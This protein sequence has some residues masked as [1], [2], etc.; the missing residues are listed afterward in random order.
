MMG[1][2]LR[3]RIAA[4]PDSDRAA[5]LAS[6]VAPLQAA[7]SAN[8]GELELIAVSLAVNASLAEFPQA[9]LPAFSAEAERGLRS[10]LAELDAESGQ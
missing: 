8:V 2:D 7:M 1:S 4:L 9:N 5:V 3:D 10:R 6:V